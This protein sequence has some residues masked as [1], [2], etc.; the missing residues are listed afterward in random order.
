MEHYALNQLGQIVYNYCG[1]NYLDNLPSLQSK[2]TKRLQD[3]GNISLYNYIK[4]IEQHPTEWEVLVEIL[5]VNETYFFREDKQLSVYQ[6][7]VLPS[8]QEKDSQQPIKVWSAA[9][10]TGEEPYSL[11]MTTLDS[12]HQLSRTVQIVGTD[13]SKRVLHTAEQG[14]YSKHSLSFRR[15]P[16]HWLKQYFTEHPDKYALNPKVKNMVEFQY[17][18]LLDETNMGRRQEYDVIFCRNVLIYFNTE[19]VKKVASSFYHSLKKGGVLFLGHAETISN[20]GIGFE[21]ISTNG[22]F[23]YRKE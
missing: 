23:Y 13:I 5:T 15:M 2:V 11:A 4:Y 18:N 20:M 19:T 9:C 21:T 17:L 8:L 3:L 6:E 12:P 14:V 1:L 16:E 22:T 10:S 7:I